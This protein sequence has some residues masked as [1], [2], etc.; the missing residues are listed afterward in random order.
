MKKNVSKI[1]LAVFLLAVVAMV[2]GASMTVSAATK[3]YTVKKSAPLRNDP[4]KQKGNEIMTVPKGAT[5][6]ANFS[7]V[8]GKYVRTTYKG[9]GGWFLKGWL[10]P[11]TDGDFRVTVEDCDLYK[12][13]SYNTKKLKFIPAGK[14]VEVLG[15][16]GEWYRVVYSGKKGYIPSEAL[17]GSS[18]TP[19]GVIGYRYTKNEKGQNTRMHDSPYLLG[20]QNKIASIPPHTR[21]AVYGYVTR[22]Q[23]GGDLVRFAYASYN[24]YKGYVAESELE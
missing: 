19:T 2:L 16:N 15:D 23:R 12:G 22:R 7:D 13:A 1:R 5:V 6:E 10:T 18:T 8:R 14:T 11:Y 4:Y 24:R 21:I 3:Q 17:D 20:D 9:A